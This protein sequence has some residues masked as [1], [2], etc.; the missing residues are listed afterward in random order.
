[1]KLTV[2]GSSG[3]IS[4]PES[5]ASC[6]LLQAHDGDRTWQVL[7]DLGPGA[8]GQAMRYVDPAQVD[9][10]LVSHLHAD[11]IADLAGLE[12]LIRYGPG[13]PR[14]PVPVYGPVGTR[15]RIVQLCGESGDPDHAFTV[16]TW[17][18]GT[19]VHVGP[20]VIEPFEVEHPVPAYAMRI[21]GPSA[22][23]A[24]T[25]VLTYTGDTDH[26]AGVT[27][28][29]RDAHVLLSEAAFQ[30]ERDQVRGIHLTGLR[31]GQLATAARAGRLI[32]THIPPWTCAATVR[33]EAT[34]TYAGPIEVAEPGATWLI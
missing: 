1:M 27:L 23:S 11:H 31:A 6:Y 13:A 21:T 18:P 30:E 19:P 5:A 22:E 3:S 9:A 33:T 8:V 20:F 14:P 10:V 26:C 28:A 4:G 2:V 17:Q 29:A 16:T 7:L 32:L 12:V 25:R 34:G 15:A 24:G